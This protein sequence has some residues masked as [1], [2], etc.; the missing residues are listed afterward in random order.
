MERK[1]VELEKDI[2]NDYINNYIGVIELSSKYNLH[3]TIIQRILLRCGIVLRKNTPKT[4]VNHF[5][6]SEY[7]ENS[8]YWAGFIL[9]DGYIRNKGRFTLSIGLQK[10]DLSHLTKF[11]DLTKFEGKIHEEQNCFKISISSKQ[12]I[13]DLLNNFELYNKKSLT[14]YISDK[15]PKKYLKDFIRGYFDGDGCISY[16]ATDTI[17]FVG[18]NKTL[19]TIRDYFYKDCKIKLRSK[20]FPNIIEHG[21]VYTLYYNGIS[22]FKC[23]DNMYL[24]ANNY[25]ERKY[26]LYLK[27]KEKYEQE[28]NGCAR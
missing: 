24:N 20:D 25:L 8:C 19:L 1:H 28:K 4:K 21:N 23:I 18:T 22:A 15:V 9:A 10:R 3:R 26:D 27:L 6:F 7:N 12:I 5:F 14:C 17:S 13:D 2:I 11:K 16:T